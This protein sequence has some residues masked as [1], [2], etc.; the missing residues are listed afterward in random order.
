MTRLAGR[1]ILLTF[2]ALGALSVCAWAQNYSEASPESVVTVL[3]A[4][5]TDAQ[6]VGTGLVVRTDGYILT[7]Y[8]LIKNARNIQVKL[9]NGEIYDNAQIAAFD[10]RRNVA[11]LRINAVGLKII[12]NGMSEETQVGSK[13]FI[14]ANPGQFVT[15]EGTLRSVQMA[16]EIVG[17]GKGYRVLDTDAA[18]A[19]NASGGLLL[20][21]SGRSLGIVTTTPDVKGRNIAVPLSS[22]LGMIRSAQNSS[23]TTTAA[24]PYK[25]TPSTTPVPIPQSNVQMPE[26]GVTPLQPAGPGSVVVKPKT[27]SE[28]LASSKTVYVESA[29]VGFKPEQLVNA[30]NKQK[31]FPDFGLTFVNERDLADLILEIDHVVFTWKYTFK[32]YSQRLGVVVATGDRIIWDGNLGADA[33][34]DRVIEKLKATRGSVKPAAAPQPAAKPED[35]KDTDKD[36]GD[37]KK[38]LL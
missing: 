6:P 12:P 15:S 17:A 34:A 23:L 35:K 5:E 14:M 29:T 20:D 38:T 13:V 31:E 19:V 8:S 24:V 2:I 1:I 18:T 7:P 3:L 36:K 25:P 10:E 37:K 22:V 21:D 26:R 30:L 16:D 33:M 28:V 11:L 27:P 9:A 32:L 4:N